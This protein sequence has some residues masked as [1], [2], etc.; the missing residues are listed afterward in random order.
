M[1]AEEL[2]AFLQIKGTMQT[3]GLSGHLQLGD[4]YSFYKPLSLKTKSRMVVS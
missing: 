1:R 3:D 4:Y 2:K